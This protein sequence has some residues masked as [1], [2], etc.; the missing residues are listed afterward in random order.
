MSTQS[1]IA[2]L[3]TAFFDRAPDAVGLAYW[4]RELDAG[5]ISFEQIAKNWVE[6]QPEGQAKYPD[7]LSTSDFI[8]AIYN[9]VLDRTADQV[10]LA[11]WQAELDAGNISRDVFVA[12]VINGAKANN[13]PQAQLDAI[14]RKSVV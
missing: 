8:A 4:V 14:D 7:S 3:Y 1:D 13:T 12:A 6:E 10:G 11:Y 5:N 2:E 9:N